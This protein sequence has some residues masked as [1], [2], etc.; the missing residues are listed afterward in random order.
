M[1]PGA[2]RWLLKRWLHH[3]RITL[4]KCLDTSDPLLTSSCNLCTTTSR[5][6]LMLT[7]RDLCTMTSRDTLR[8]LDVDG[9][10]W[11]ERLG[12]RWRWFLEVLGGSK[13][14]LRIV[15]R[16]FLKWKKSFLFLLLIGCY[17]LTVTSHKLK[18]CWWRH[19]EVLKSWHKEILEVYW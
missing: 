15:A 7:S 2:R 17:E 9:R 4:E 18:S 6:S 3:Q 12:V 5:D 10:Q 13:D 16:Q 19:E 11:C 8:W 14:D 1:V